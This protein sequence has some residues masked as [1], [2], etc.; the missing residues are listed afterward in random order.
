ML[1]AHSTLLFGITYSLSRY[2]LPLHVVLTI[3]AAVVPAAPRAAW[4]GLRRTPRVTGRA[5]AFVA[6]VRFLGAAWTR[7]PAAAARH[8]C[9]GGTGSSLQDG[10]NRA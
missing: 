9:H 1:L 3:G 4:K 5:R 8:G 2:T 6:M 10:A 7:D